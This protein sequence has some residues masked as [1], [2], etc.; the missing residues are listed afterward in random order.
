MQ[1]A[2]MMTELVYNNQNQS[3]FK[4]DYTFPKS[5]YNAFLSFEFESEDSIKTNSIAEKTKGET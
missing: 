5:V 1:A 4:A 3:F 2:V